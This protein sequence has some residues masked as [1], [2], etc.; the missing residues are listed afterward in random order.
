M[1]QIPD[2][3][4]RQQYS[5]RKTEKE[6]QRRR[7]RSI[8]IRNKRKESMGVAKKNTARLRKSTKT[9]VAPQIFSLMDNSD[10]MIDFLD[11]LVS[12][13]RRGKDVYVDLS[14]IKQLSQDGILALLSRTH[15]PKFSYGRNVSGAE[16]DQPE[17]QRIFKESGVY[18]DH[19]LELSGA[20]RET[21]GHIRRRESKVVESKTAKE[22]VQFALS[23]LTV[24]LR[25]R[26]SSFETL[27]ECMSNTFT[28]AG[29]QMKR[30]EL[31]WTSV[32]YNQQTKR[33][34]F[35]FMDNGVG[36]C[37]SL[38]L[39]LR[40]QIALAFGWKDNSD[41]LKDVLENRIG[42][43][44][45]LDFRGKGLPSIHKRSTDGYLKNLIIITNN[46]YANVQ[47]N[48]YKVLQ[49]SLQGTFVHWEIEGDEKKNN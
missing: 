34:S 29:F 25:H 33:A 8:E 16:P 42:S 13:T 5:Q 27:V 26:A 28:H 6:L 19:V 32:R 10:E 40:N 37:R 44:T 36:I 35:L 3:V 2:K 47:A 48:E 38:D 11:E 43:R 46:A 22:L 21:S 4:K 18:G 24:E 39:K 12:T 20:Y 31:W 49:K 14:G 17:L 41:L 23:R 1:K 7:N 30:K 9:L 15:D 45:G